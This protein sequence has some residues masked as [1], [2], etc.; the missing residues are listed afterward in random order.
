MALCTYSLQNVIDWAR[1]QVKLIPL[2][3]VGGF[4]NEPALTICNSVMQEILSEPFNWKW[5]R[6]DASSFDTID[7]TQDYVRTITNLGWLESCVLE[8][9]A[10]TSTPKPVREIEVVRVLPKTSIVADPVKIAVMNETDSDVTFR[11]MPI[12]ASVIWTVYPVYQK[13]PLLKTAMNDKWDPIPDELSY[14]Y[15]QG[16][17]AL[18]KRHAESPDWINE[19]QLFLSMLRKALGIENVEGCNEGFYPERPILI[20]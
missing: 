1:T 7:K 3:G 15:K 5:N 18:A 17:L 11:F 19:Y 12:P 10:N 14:V 8:D 16:F 9:K 13:K 6:I 20:G 4:T 2:V